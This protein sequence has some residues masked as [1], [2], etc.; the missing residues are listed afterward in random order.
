M[1]Y[2][3]LLAAHLAISLLVWLGIQFHIL[4]VHPYMFF[5]ALLLPF[6]GVL[7]VLILH[8]QIFFRADN[9]MDIGVEK[10]KLKSELYKSV[11][12]DEKEI[13]ATAVPKKLNAAVVPSVPSTPIS[14]SPITPR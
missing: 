6:W 13:A 5:V 3:M 11:T 2:V 14:A 7:M 12:V 4:K 8:F 1:I 9:S 10:M